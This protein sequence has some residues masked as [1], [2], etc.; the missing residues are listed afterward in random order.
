MSEPGSHPDQIHHK[1][2]MSF[3]DGL[4]E[5]TD[6]T[7]LLLANQD[8]VVIS[9]AGPMSNDTNVGKT[10][11]GNKIAEELIL[12]DIPH[13]VVSDAEQLLNP[14]NKSLL[15]H[16]QQEA[17]SKKGVVILSATNSPSGEHG[18]EAMEKFSAYKNEELKKKDRPSVCPRALPGSG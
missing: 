4:K 9:I 7:K 18:K 12:Q 1:I 5:I 8:Y 13:I 17:E 11:L 16:R 2:E 15:E 6:K 14:N 3:A 10:T